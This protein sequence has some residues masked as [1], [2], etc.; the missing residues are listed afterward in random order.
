MWTIEG[1]KVIVLGDT[2]THGGQVITAAETVFYLDRQVARVGDQVTCPKCKG[3]HT[4]ASGAPK[5]YALGMQIARNGDMISCGARLIS[6]SG[7]VDGMTANH[8]RRLSE[9]EVYDEQVQIVDE[10]TGAPL[11]FYPFYI[12]VSDGQIVS[13]ETNGEGC[14]PRIQTANVEHL[15]IW[16]GDEAEEKMRGNDGNS[17]A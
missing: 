7:V 2:T 4:I 12:E 6:G 1:E 14:T 5:A 13:G 17:E 10:K 9:P 16:T 8:A 11:P 15:Q 3:V